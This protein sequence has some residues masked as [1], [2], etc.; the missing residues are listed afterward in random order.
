MASAGDARD[1]NARTSHTVATLAQQV[2]RLAQ[3]VHLAQQ[4]EALD[5]KE[6]D[7]DTMRCDALIGGEPCDERERPARRYFVWDL[8]GHRDGVQ[9][10]ARCSRG[11]A[12]VR[13]D[14]VL[15]EWWA[16][17]VVVGRSACGGR[18]GAARCR[19]ERLIRNIRGDGAGV[20]V[21]RDGRAL[22]P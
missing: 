19:V 7:I 11:G 13:S 2:Q 15:E 6:H 5:D 12:Q 20:R 9:R 14:I 22:G 21:G 3:H 16:A 4:H 18:V 17:E 10:H 1:R 8:E